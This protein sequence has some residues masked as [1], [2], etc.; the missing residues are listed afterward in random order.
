MTDKNCPSCSLKGKEI[1]E[2]KLSCVELEKSIKKL[3]HALKACNENYTDADDRLSREGKLR[4]RT[5]DEL[6]EQQEMHTY[7]SESSISSKS[8]C[9]SS[10]E[11]S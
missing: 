3:K 1:K 11:E 9:S 7:N 8:S 6:T 10:S 4:T 5:E 2:L